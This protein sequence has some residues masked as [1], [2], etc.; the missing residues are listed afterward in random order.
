LSRG[1]ISLVLIRYPQVFLV[2]V[3]IGGS[4]PG[5]SLLG[6]GIGG[7]VPVNVFATGAPLHGSKRRSTGGTTIALANEFSMQWPV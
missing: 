3:L 7:S 2:Y 6:M 5:A 4:V 1:A